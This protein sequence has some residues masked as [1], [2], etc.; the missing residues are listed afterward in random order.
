MTPQPRPVALDMGLLTCQ[1]V[2]TDVAVGMGL[3]YT[4][5]EFLEGRCNRRMTKPIPRLPRQRPAPLSTLG[6][7]YGESL[8]W[9]DL[10]QDDA[11]TR[12]MQS[13]R[14]AQSIDATGGGLIPVGNGTR[15]IEAS[16]QAL[17][18][19][20]APESSTDTERSNSR[21]RVSFAMPSAIT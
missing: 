11:R 4:T 3:E 19:R 17:Y 8:G 20:M 5:P 18:R 10:G 6:F 21:H 12:V 2:H 15:R 14:L 16:R 7:F 1:C 9:D 13:V